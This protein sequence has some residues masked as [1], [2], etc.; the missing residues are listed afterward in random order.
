MQNVS[1]I[2]GNIQCAWGS[3]HNLDIGYM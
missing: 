3:S 1:F 2:S